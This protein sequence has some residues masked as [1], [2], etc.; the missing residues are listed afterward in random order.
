MAPPNND[1]YIEEEEDYWYGSFPAPRYASINRPLSPALSICASPV[2]LATNNFFT[3]SPLCIEEFDLSDRNFRPCPCGYQVCRYQRGS[4]L[5]HFPANA[6]CSQI[7]QF[8]FNNIRNNMNGLC[9]ACRRPYDDKTIQWKVVTQEEY[10]RPPPSPATRTSLTT[11]T[12]S[13][14][15]RPISKRI[16]RSV[17]K[18]SDRRRPR[19]EKLRKTAA[20][21][22]LACGLFRRTWF[23]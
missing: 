6:D 5:R 18:N 9:P 10:V 13:P 14:N 8:C 7:C 17:P 11:T 19:S 23:M 12:G 2:E 4:C 15:L 3:H 1:S 21:I 16:R 22:W 20:R